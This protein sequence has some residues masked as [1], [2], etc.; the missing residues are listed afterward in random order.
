[1]VLPWKSRIRILFEVLIDG[2]ASLV[3]PIL[4][5]SGGHRW[6]RVPPNERNGRVH[7]STVTV[8]AFQVAQNDPEWVLREQDIRV[9]TTRDT[10]P[11]GQHRNTTDSC[12]V[13]RH[14]PT[15]IEAKAAARS[16]HQNRRLARQMLEAR[17]AAH[18]QALLEANKE[19]DRKAKVGSGE[20]ADKIRTYREK[21]DR[22]TDH[23]SGKKVSLGRVIRGELNLLW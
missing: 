23:R 15:G 1:M 3:S 13:M 22:V 17:V 10:G 5:E 16:Q 14:L 20:R 18:Y 21:D 9:F 7:T 6:Q 8:A 11:G 19:Q 4:D 12:V 2:D